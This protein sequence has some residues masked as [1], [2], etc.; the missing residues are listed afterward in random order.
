MWCGHN[1]NKKKACGR[2]AI[3][4]WKDNYT[5]YSLISGQMKEWGNVAG[6]KEN[7]CRSNIIMVTLRTGDRCL[8][9]DEVFRL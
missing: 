4:V 3:L 6:G 2:V 5:V 1:D 7:C 9:Q 8:F